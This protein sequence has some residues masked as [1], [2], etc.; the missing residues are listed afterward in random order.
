MPDC[1]TCKFYDPHPFV[2]ENDWDDWC[3][4]YGMKLKDSNC[5]TIFCNHYKK[6]D[7]YDE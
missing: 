2:R 3:D 1:E 7:E 4:Y 6:S 5:D